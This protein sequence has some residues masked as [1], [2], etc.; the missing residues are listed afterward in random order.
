MSSLNRENT[1]ERSWS[2]LPVFLLASGLFSILFPALLLTSARLDA[3]TEIGSIGHT[4]GY[5]LCLL[6]G[7]FLILSGIQRRQVFVVSAISVLGLLSYITLVVSTTDPQQSPVTF[8]MSRYGLLLWV[9]LGA[10]SALT[11]EH[12]RSCK[13]RGKHGV[14]SQTI[15]FLTF[16]LVAYMSTAFLMRFLNNPVVTLSYQIVANSIIVLMM[17]LF[18]LAEAY[19]E[20]SKPKIVYLSLIVIGTILAFTVSLL[21][22]TAIVAFWGALLI[23]VFWRSFTTLSLIRKMLLT[24]SLFLAWVLIS[25]SVAFQIFILGTRFG[26]LS[27]GG[28]SLSS[29]TSRFQILTSFFDQFAVS[30]VFGHFR[31]E[32]L[33][34]AGEGNF[35]HSL[36]LSFL[37]HTGAIGFLWIVAIILSLSY[38]R[39]AQGAIV[40][41]DKLSIYLFVLVLALGSISAFLTWLP[42]WYIIGFICIRCTYPRHGVGK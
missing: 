21:Q 14:L 8:L 26:E 17:Y 20:H 13:A 28:G 34:F 5:F 24:L 32:I 30:P 11:V 29:L 31:S 22:S 41:Y 27:D 33:S 19:W 9:V 10:T 18:L 6:I 12:L 37:S 35:P 1:H 42:F 3:Y 40:P 15:V 16:T 25:Q 36:P 23:I 7:V 2:Q 4:G 38:Q 39:W